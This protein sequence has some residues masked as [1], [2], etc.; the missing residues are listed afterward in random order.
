MAHASAEH[1]LR[2]IHLVAGIGAVASLITVLV[3]FGFAESRGFRGVC[4]VAGF[5]FV[6]A[7]VFTFRPRAR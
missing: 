6:I 7:H 4:L 1:R 3:S 5:A 2:R